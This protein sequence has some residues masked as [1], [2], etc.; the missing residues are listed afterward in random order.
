MDLRLKKLKQQITGWVYFFPYSL[1]ETVLTEIDAKLRKRIRVIIW[2]QWK[3]PRK[4]YDSLRKL[5]ATHRN[6]YV[7]ANCRK[8][9]Q[10][11][12]N[13]ATI[14]AAITNKRLEKKVGHQCQT[15]SLKSI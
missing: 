12:Y 11:V 1:Y 14:H 4:K 9:Y 13:T 3:K 8:R 5:G 2:K 7:T 15:S 10:Y 6:A